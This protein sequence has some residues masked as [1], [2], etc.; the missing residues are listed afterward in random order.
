M[1]GQRQDGFTLIELIV[2]I[3]ILGILAATALPRFVNLA[4][5]AGNAAAAG[6]AGSVASASSMNFS[7]RLINTNAG[8]AMNGGAV[9][10]V[11]SNFTNLVS[12]VNFTAGATP[13]TPTDDQ[14]FNISGVGNCAAVG[15]GNPVTCTI[16]GRNGSATATVIC[17]N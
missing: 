8:F 14:T 6:V 3:V 11:A 10:Q 1:V 13:V 12:G 16:T 17:S 5:D 9:C 2:V 7:R 4:G 15:A